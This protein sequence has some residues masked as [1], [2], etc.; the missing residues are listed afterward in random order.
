MPDTTS[1]PLSPIDHI[2]TGR[3]AYPIEFVFAYRGEI[4]PERLRS[5]FRAVLEQFPPASSTLVRVS[6]H[7]YVFEPGDDGASFETV[8][9]RAS[10]GDAAARVEFLDPV[11]SV[12]GE[13]LTR[14]RLT[15]TPRG[16]VLGVSMSHAVVD[17]FSFFH[18][19]SSWAALFHGKR[20]IGPFHLREVLCP[21]VGS[22]RQPA[23][24]AGLRDESGVFWT[25]R[26]PMIDRARIEWDRRVY[27]A[28]ELRDLLGQIQK[29][30]EVRLSYNDVV[31]AR[32]WRKY[33]AKW[34][35]GDPDEL[36]YINCPVDFRRSLDA[37]PRNYFGCA[38]SLASGAL[39][40]GK[41]AEASDTE[42]ALLVHDAVGGVD[43]K[44]IGSSLRALERVRLQ[45]G[46]AVLDRLHV[47]HPSRGLLVT[48]ISR[49]PVL[50]IEFDAG[51]PVAFDILTPVHRGAVVL[52]ADDG[53]DVRVCYIPDPDL[54]PET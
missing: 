24:P 3:G 31:T 25:R 32:L 22:N 19:L 12:P 43:E 1:I 35:A 14:V 34:Y 15:R 30:C 33:G 4:D 2:F 46:L 52:P 49:L 8:E 20:T 53:L 7:S 16:S 17:G 18:F 5:S 40:H 29:D 47:T 51:P 28:E 41:L 9:S 23:T 37:C 42:L 26:R 44:R 11:D 21:Q 54:P 50:Q 6:D 45:E 48:N 38:V 10:F 13:P 36:A 27:S 39:P